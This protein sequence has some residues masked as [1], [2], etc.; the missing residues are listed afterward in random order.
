MIDNF[1]EFIAAIER[2]PE[3]PVYGLTVRDR[4]MIEDHINNC[5]KC[6]A[7]ADRVNEKYNK[8]PPTIGFNLN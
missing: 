4:L 7:A 6:G 8:R 3:A 5:E 1:C 2:D